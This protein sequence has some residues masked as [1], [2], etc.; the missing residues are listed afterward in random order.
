MKKLLVTAVS[1]MGLGAM[2]AFGAV[3][4]ACSVSG[5]TLSFAISTTTGNSYTCGDK[6]FSNFTNPNGVSGTVTLTELNSDQYKVSFLA[7]GGGITTSF[8][9]GFDV[10]VAAAFPTWDISQIQ[11][12]M[13]TGV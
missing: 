8:S 11:A 13:Q 6:V 2:S 9:F 3:V 7:A 12:S 4:P 10:Q 5:D 1:L